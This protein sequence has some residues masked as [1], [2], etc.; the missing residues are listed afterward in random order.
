[1]KPEQSPFASKTRQ[2]QQQRWIE[3]QCDREALTPVEQT[4]LPAEDKPPE[5]VLQRPHHSQYDAVLKK[6]RQAI[7]RAGDYTPC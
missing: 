5:I 1:M 3:W 6:M 7:G 2:E 4:L